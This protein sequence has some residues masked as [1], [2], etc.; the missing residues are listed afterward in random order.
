VEAV[1]AEGRG[2][3]RLWDRLVGRDT[4]AQRYAPLTGDEWTYLMSSYGQPSAE[5]IQPTFVQYATQAYAGNSVVFAVIGQRITLFSE[6]TF[7]YRSLSDKHLFGDESLK[8]LE[9]PWPNGTTADLLARMEQDVSLAGNAYI[10]DAGSQLERLRPDW[11]TIVSEVSRDALGRQVREVR[12]YLFEPIGDSERTTEFY[13]VDEVAH[14]A[15]IPDPLAN[16]R[17]MSWLTPVIREID[18]DVAMLQHQQ[19]F[20][21]NAASPNM[22][23]KYQGKL[24]EEQINRIR[25]A[26][27]ARHAGPRNAGGTMVLDQGAD[28]TI[29]GDRMQGSAFSDLRAA[30]ESR[31]ASAGQVPPLLAGLKEG[32]QAS[33]PGEY[34][35]AMRKFADGLIRS[36]WRGVCGALSAIVEVPAGAQ[37]WVDTSDITALQP[38]ESD[39]AGVM[40]QQAGTAN[41]LIIAGF[42]PPSVLKAITA[43]DLTLLEHS[44]MTS[45]QLYKPGEN[46]SAATPDNPPPPTD[47]KP[48]GDKPTDSVPVEPTAGDKAASGKAPPKEPAKPS[49]RHRVGRNFDPDQPRNPDGQWSTVGAATNHLF[50]IGDLEKT[51]GHQRADVRF[52]QDGHVRVMDGGALLVTFDSG[53][54]NQ[55]I[56][57]NIEDPSDA[58]DFAGDIE[59][60]ATTDP[61]GPDYVGVDPNPNGLIDWVGGDG[62]SYLVGLDPAGDVRVGWPNADGGY[63]EFD[64]GADDAR[65][66][67][68]S[69]VQAADEMDSVLTEAEG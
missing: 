58:R 62:A 43:N 29:V 9:T 57:A 10:R 15:P 36:N 12:G 1:A 41:T 46:N 23:V 67:A 13:L 61:E 45:V 39:A 40:Q 54:G 69:L 63:D 7:K 47:A 38:G 31:I 22:V 11:V 33:S 20:Y 55:E 6:A 26:I 24:V 56:F 27:A 16:F 44:G 51:F 52:G 25:N 21:N 28:L 34:P 5:K 66:M 49:G 8:K 48:T 32:M 64:I 35:Q 18:A 14:W 37:L 30:G 60:A 42:T 2:V 50:S 53:D 4:A 3:T 59:W 65:S 17:G 19:A 68:D